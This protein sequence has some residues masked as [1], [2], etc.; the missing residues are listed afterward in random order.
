MKVRFR[1]TPPPGG[2]QDLTCSSGNPSGLLRRS[3][4]CNTHPPTDPA[5]ISILNIVNHVF[6]ALNRVRQGNTLGDINIS[7]TPLTPGKVECFTIL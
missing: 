6:A 2:G 3:A 4:A 7:F 1:S 5:N